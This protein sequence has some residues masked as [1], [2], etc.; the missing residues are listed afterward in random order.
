MKY[1]KYFSY[2]FF[3]FFQFAVWYIVIGINSIVQ[4]LCYQ[5]F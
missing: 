4:S 1:E 3:E 2:I 5:L